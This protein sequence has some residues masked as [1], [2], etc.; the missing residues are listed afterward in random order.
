M[1]ALMESQTTAAYVSI[2]EVLKRK[3]GGNAMTPSF[4]IA[5]IFVYANYSDVIF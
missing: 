5:G 1:W 2:F 3:L 4:I